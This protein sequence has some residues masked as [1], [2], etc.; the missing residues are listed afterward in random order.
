[1]INIL[2]ILEIPL[3][4]VVKRNTF[5]STYVSVLAENISSSRMEQKA[6]FYLKNRY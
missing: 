6:D 4:D 3:P 1:M 2:I 5:G